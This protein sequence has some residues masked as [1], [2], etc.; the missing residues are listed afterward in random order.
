MKKRILNHLTKLRPYTI[1]TVPRGGSE[2]LQSLLDGN[3]KILLYV[4]NFQFFSNYIENV[5]CRYKN[6]IISA[7]D[8]IYEFVGNEIWRFNTLYHYREGLDRLG[9]DM[10][11]SL[12]INK[13]LF[14]KL[15][16]EITNDY[17]ITDKNLLLSLYASYHICLGRDI[18]KTKINIFLNNTY[19][20]NKL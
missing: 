4:L 2:Y 12:N 3:P 13:N 20:N 8:F 1:I 7:E 6:K 14:I 18:F 10:N 17:E 5:K 11:E 9:S 19:H 15:F 16:L